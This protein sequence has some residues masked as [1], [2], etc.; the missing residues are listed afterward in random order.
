MQN[1]YRDFFFY[2]LFIYNTLQ[3]KIRFYKTTKFAPLRT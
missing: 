2:I 3:T 1:A